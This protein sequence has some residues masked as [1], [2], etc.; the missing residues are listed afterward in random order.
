MAV[1]EGVLSLSDADG[2]RD[3]V[4]KDGLNGGQPV[5]LGQD[6]GDAIL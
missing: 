4:G 2:L 1:F 3:L 5:F 6:R